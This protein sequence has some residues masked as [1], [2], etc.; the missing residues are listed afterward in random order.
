MVP[1]Y[2]RYLSCAVSL[3]IFQIRLVSSDYLDLD[4]DDSLRQRIP[5][6]WE[7]GTTSGNTTR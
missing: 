4:L 2:S 5:R 3:Q 7:G 1:F 6:Q